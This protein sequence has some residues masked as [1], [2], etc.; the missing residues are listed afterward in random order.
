[1]KGIESNE[2]FEAV[3]EYFA[4]NKEPTMA[5]RFL[6]NMLHEDD[7][8]LSDDQIYTNADHL[9]NWLLL[10]LLRRHRVY[11]LVVFRAKKMRIKN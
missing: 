4:D 10:S 9:K 8:Q 5:Y 1:M 3:K 2:Y 6:I 11:S 7:C